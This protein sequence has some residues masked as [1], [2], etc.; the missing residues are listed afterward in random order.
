M[1]STRAF[2][3]CGAFPHLLD[4]IQFQFVGRTCQKPSDVKELLIPDCIENSGW[5]HE[6]KEDADL[7]H[8][9]P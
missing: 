3:L 8:C 7:P 4:R 1:K 5:A 9:D 2:H 6:E